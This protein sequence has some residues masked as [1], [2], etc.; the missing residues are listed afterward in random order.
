MI[1][2]TDSAKEHLKNIL[3]AHSDDLDFSLRLVA[4]PAG[5]LGFVL[6]SEA[7]EDGQVIEHEGA[8]VLVVSSELMSVVEGMTLDIQDTAE[9]PKLIAVKEKTE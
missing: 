8:K 5:R 2:V 1:T 6:E 9:G 4:K 7:K 3:L